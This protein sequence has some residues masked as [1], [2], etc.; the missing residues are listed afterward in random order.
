MALSVICLYSHL[1][2]FIVDPNL[3]S[4]FMKNDCYMSYLEKI[5]LYI[6]H[7]NTVSAQ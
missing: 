6:M 4:F 1:I 2:F 7:V 5:E 3:G